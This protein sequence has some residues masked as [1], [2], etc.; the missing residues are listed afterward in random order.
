VLTC[1][2]SASLPG[3]HASLQARVDMEFLLF[4]DDVKLSSSFGMP[5]P[6]TSWVTT[7]I[8][9]LLAVLT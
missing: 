5:L 1:F 7:D 3:L 8:C 6:D 2:L 9:R 4:I